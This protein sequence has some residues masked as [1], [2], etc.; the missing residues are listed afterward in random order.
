[1]VG[2]VSPAPGTPPG[3]SSLGWGVDRSL[4]W[5]VLVGDKVPVPALGFAA[6]WEAEFEGLSE[7]EEVLELVLWLGVL[8]GTLKEA[9]EPV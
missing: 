6:F 5:L 7:A 1:M 3:R 8:R 2:F 4:H 9:M